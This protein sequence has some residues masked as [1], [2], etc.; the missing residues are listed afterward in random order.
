MYRNGFIGW[1]RVVTTIPRTVP[2][3]PRQPY[4]V[5]GHQAVGLQWGLPASNGGAPV[6]GF[7][8]QLSL[9]GTNWRDWTADGRPWSVTRA[10]RSTSLV[11]RPTN[12]LLKTFIV[13]G[14][15]VWV[16]VA[17]VNAAGIGPF[18]TLGSAVPY[19]YPS[20]PRLRQATPGFRSIS[21]AWS[22]P[23][24]TGYPRWPP[25]PSSWRCGERA[26]GG[27][28]CARERPRSR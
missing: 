26:R 14:R 8:V 20:A 27:P 16:R 9:N 23:T 19:T 5:S 6:T 28:S 21:L 24:F 25:T 18:L 15:R 3:A 7:R 10:F 1:S 4:I 12:A 13:P 11:L 2:T 17:A 22:A